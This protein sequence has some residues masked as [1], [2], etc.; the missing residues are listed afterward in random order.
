MAARITEQKL[1]SKI[2]G[3][4][5][6]CPHR[7][8]LPVTDDVIRRHHSGQGDDGRDFVMSTYPMLLYGYMLLE[9]A[10]DLMM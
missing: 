4:G 8:F 9:S 2:R 1:L 7:R 3:E 6:G 10:V 5:C